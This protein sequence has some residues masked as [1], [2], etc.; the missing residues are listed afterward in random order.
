MNSMGRITAASAISEARLPR[1]SF[2]A[3]TG[4]SMP[5]KSTPRPARMK[6]PGSI[7]QNGNRGS[8]SERDLRGFGIVDGQVLSGQMKFEKGGDE[9]PEVAQ[10]LARPLGPDDHDQGHE[11][12]HEQGIDQHRNEL[13]PSEECA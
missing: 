3:G 7:K 10:R 5:L 1:I 4:N 8:D 9:A 2:N 13:L 11:A 12:V 6:L